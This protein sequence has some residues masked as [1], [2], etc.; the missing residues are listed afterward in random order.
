M[1]QSARRVPVC[2]WRNIPIT[3]SGFESLGRCSIRELRGLEY[4][5][6]MA[7]ASKK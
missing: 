5:E 4:P 7:I 6:I 1:G 2:N 3:R